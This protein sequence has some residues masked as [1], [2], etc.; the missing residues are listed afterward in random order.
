M[1]SNV[2][3]LICL[4]YIAFFPYLNFSPLK[5]NPN[6]PAVRKINSCN[7][8]CNFLSY[9]ARF[10]KESLKIFNTKRKHC[11]SYNRRKTFKKQN[12]DHLSFLFFVPVKEC[13]VVIEFRGLALGACISCDALHNALSPPDF[14][15]EWLKI[16]NLTIFLNLPF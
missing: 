16:Y 15:I 6:R 4:F 9:D 8:K 5:Q 11:I 10:L 7:I 13:S 3:H 12:Q 2:S 1:P 14:Q